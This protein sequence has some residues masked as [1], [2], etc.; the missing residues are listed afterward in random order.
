V[1]VRIYICPIDFLTPPA[2]PRTGYYPRLMQYV[3]PGRYMV[4]S[5]TDSDGSPSLPWALGVAIASDWSAVDADAQMQLIAEF[6]AAVVTFADAK[7]YLKATTIA[8]LPAAVVNKFKTIFDTLG[9][10]YN[11]FLGTTIL[12]KVWQRLASWQEYASD[13][14]AMDAFR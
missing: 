9:I 10:P 11:D 3:S 14:F 6:P 2:V 1:T 5:K 7:T 4:G 13:S 8:D 12:A